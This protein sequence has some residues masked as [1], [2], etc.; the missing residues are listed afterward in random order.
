[1]SATP[2]EI[3]RRAL[4]DHLAALPSAELLARYAKKNDPEAFAG[5][6]Q[7][8]GPL[9][10]G[11]CRRVLGSAADADDAFQAVFL[12][13]ARQ[14][15]SFRD[16]RAL[17]AWLHRVA[18]RV[19]RKAPARRAAE[20]LR[21]LTP[22]GSPEPVDPNDPFAG[23]AWKDLRRVLDEELDALPEKFRGP[24]VLCWLDG[25][26]QDEAAGRLGTSLNTLKRRLDAGRELL[27]ARLTRRGLAPVLAAAAILNPTG[28]RAVLPDALAVLAVEHALPGA[29]IPTGVQ[30]LAALVAATTSARSYLK[31]G[32]AFVLVAGVVSA[33]VVALS[34][35]PPLEPARPS[36][37]LP[38]LSTPEAPAAKSEPKPVSTIIPRNRISG[39]GPIAWSPDGKTIAGHGTLGVSLWDVDTT[40]ETSTPWTRRD[41][42]DQNLAITVLEFS[43]DGKMLAF[44]DYR[45]TV[46]LLDVA[47]NKQVAEFTGVPDNGA[48]GGMRLSWSADSR[49]LAAMGGDTVLVWDVTTKRQKP[50]IRPYGR[51]TTSKFSAMALSPDGKTVATGRSTRWSPSGTW[52]A[53][54]RRRYPETKNSGHHHCLS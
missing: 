33:G 19:A 54:S 29:T 23:V 11:V 51:P 21:G 47:A 39:S 24:V 43:P 10:L 9:V 28:L 30:A 42:P 16:A 6:V 2:T 26:T 8:F 17:P 4:A 34:D 22:P 45:G 25:L 32:L 41:A 40:K 3:A 50:M 15:G 52:T 7:Q 5:L 53:A 18:L 12:A 37:A 27:R 20:S 14:A 48:W 38:D 46:R 36:A 44:A 35:K 31:V 49:L 1:M 13:L